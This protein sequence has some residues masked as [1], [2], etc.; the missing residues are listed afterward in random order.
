LKIFLKELLKIS[1]YTSILDILLIAKQKKILRILQNDR[2]T[3]R[4]SFLLGIALFNL[5]MS[6]MIY[7]SYNTRARPAYYCEVYMPTDRLAR[8][9]WGLAGKRHAHRCKPP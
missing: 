5:W 2:E 7:F 6:I 8:G 1:S 3:F 4:L 9:S